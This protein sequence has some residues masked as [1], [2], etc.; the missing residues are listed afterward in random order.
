MIKNWP[1]AERPR[2]RILSAGPEALSDSELL[3]ILLR[4]GMRGLDVVSWSRKLLAEHGGLRGLLSGERE[5]LLKIKGLG[6][7]RVA[8]LCAVSEMAKRVARESS[9]RSD[10]VREPSAVV[11]YL[12]AALRDQPREIFKVL[13]LDKGNQILTDEDLFRGTVDEAAVYP[14]EILKQALLK[15]ATA[16]IL[17]HNHP[18]GRTEPSPEDKELTRKIIAAASPLSVKVLD[19]II[20]G[21]TGYFSFAEHGLV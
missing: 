4:T 18:S 8:A 1:E 10:P 5:T 20:I 3:A 19:H 2:E 7:A 6:L 12:Q 9:R 13:Y 21:G 16:V 11:Q 15:N 17:V 14:R